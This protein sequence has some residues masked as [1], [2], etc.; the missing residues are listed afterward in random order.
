MQIFRLL[1]LSIPVDESSLGSPHDKALPTVKDF[2]SKLTS[3]D[4]Q[5]A[6]ASI[7]EPLSS[8]SLVL[9]TEVPKKIS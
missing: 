1:S 6:D 8:N 7:E 9:N 4:V 5:W 2:K 3:H